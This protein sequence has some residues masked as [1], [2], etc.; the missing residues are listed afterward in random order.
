[1][2]RM[3]VLFVINPKSG[4]QTDNLLDDLIQQQAE[5]SRFD[6]RTYKMQENDEEHIN[7]LILEYQPDRVAAAGGDGTV[8]L[9][10]G[11]LVGTG[12]PL[13]IIPS[14]SANGMAKE[15]D[16]LRVDQA[17][18]LLEDGV[19]K[20][21]DVVK[22]NDIISIHLADVG[23]NARIVKRFEADT[24]R[25]ILTYARHLFGEIF[26]M[27]HYKFYI[28][29]DGKE[30]KRKAV[31]L[32]FANASKYG[33]GA[34]INPKGIIDDGLFELVIVK[35][36]PDIKLLSIA[37][38]MFRNKLHTSDYVEVISCNTADVRCN[39]RTTLQVDGEVIGKVKEFHI[40]MM[41]KSLK[42]LVP[43]KS[44]D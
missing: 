21:I 11:L 2:S 23:V 32:T 10:A 14:G 30:I 26:L 9:L 34:V 43:T 12:I 25:G 42:V 35:P 7:N 24:R 28:T 29:Y 37:W 4:V 20:A 15:L 17:I 44:L 13:L 38:K 8:N 41:H 33:T 6:F 18:S 22:I 5:L 31:S 3:K 36:F 1:M 40:E 27:K 16:I 19:E 39:R